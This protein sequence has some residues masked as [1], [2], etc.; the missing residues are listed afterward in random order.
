MHARTAN[1]KEFKG[2]FHSP[3][4]VTQKTFT[5]Q[6]AKSGGTRQGAV[7]RD[8]AGVLWYLKSDPLKYC[9]KEVIA[10]HIYRLIAGED[11]APEVQLVNIDNEWMIASKWRANLKEYTFDKGQAGLEAMIL[12]TFIIGDS[13]TIKNIGCSGETIFRFDFGA[14][15]SLTKERIDKIASLFSIYQLVRAVSA[16]TKVIPFVNPSIL[17]AEIKTISMKL[18]NFNWDAWIHFYN[19]N[20]EP[21]KEE[22]I[23]ELQ[24]AFV[25]QNIAALTTLS[26]AAEREESINPLKLNSTFGQALSQFYQK[27]ENYMYPLFT[28]YA[29][30]MAQEHFNFFQQNNRHPAYYQTLVRIA[31]QQMEMHTLYESIGVL[32]LTGTDYKTD[33]EYNLYKT[34]VEEDKKIVS[35]L[36]SVITTSLLTNNA[37]AKDSTPAP[38]NVTIMPK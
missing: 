2:C 36:P 5:W 3:N 34:V 35:A 22:A 10:S 28:N 31:T 8:E 6:Q 27:I 25:K 14:G 20:V 1:P 7:Y 29:T 30:R 33:Y 24:F 17:L 11:A 37:P 15:L 38:T 21:P 32:H 13:D 4:G 9:I 12:A 23:I 16:P 18:A 19:D 26:Q